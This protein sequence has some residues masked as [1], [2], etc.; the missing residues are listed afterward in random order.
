[1]LHRWI[2]GHGTWYGNGMNKFEKGMGIGNWR[3]AKFVLQVIILGEFVLQAI[4]LGISRSLE[5]GLFCSEDARRIAC[6]PYKK[7]ARNHNG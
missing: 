2:C 7:G 5:L 6:Q 3:L 4:I 1:M